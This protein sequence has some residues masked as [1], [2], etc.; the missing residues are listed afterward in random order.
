MITLLTLAYLA[1]FVGCA[2]P[3]MA[4][5]VRRQ[6]SADMSVWR[7]WALLT[8]IC[9]QFSVF[10]LAGVRDWRVLV[11]PIASFTSIAVLLA[12][13]YRYRRA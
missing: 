3:Q 1:L 11:S 6:S 2:A 13:V 10:V 8:G 5:L 7:E 4:R 9:L 12:L